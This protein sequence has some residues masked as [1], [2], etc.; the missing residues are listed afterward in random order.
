MKKRS[1]L[2]M[3]F[4]VAIGIIAG[5]CFG[6]NSS[7]SAPAGKEM[8][9]AT[10]DEQADKIVSNMT[11]SQKIGQLMMIGIEGKTLDKNA[12]YMLN[13]YKFGNLILFDRNMDNPDQVRKLTGDMKKAVKKNSGVEPL[14]ALDQEGGLVLRMRAHF[15]AIPSE[16]EIGRQD[17][18]QAKKWAM[19]T[20]DELKKLGF[21]VDFAPVV[22]LGSPRGR[23][24]SNDPDKVITYASQACQG[25]KESGVWSALK[26]FPGIGKAKIDP[27]IDGD[28]VSIS[29]AE[30]EQE[31]MK[32]F[33]ELIKTVDNNDTF[34]M[35]SNVT[36]PMLDSQYP[37]C[38]S[39]RI[40]TDI[41]RNEYG[42]KGL[43]L[44]DDMEM[45]AMSKHYAFEDMGVRAILAGADMVIV[46]HEYG[47]EQEVYNGLLKAYRDGRLSHEMVDE[48]VTRIVKTKLVHDLNE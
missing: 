34:V 9:A 5:G 29:R 8:K 43:I 2:I 1:G 33:R 11:E 21:N 20:G 31:D 3:A 19:T 46:C 15:P 24:F 41:L 39:E 44:T 18:S 47:H 36:Y 40:M 28:S 14:I 10:I 30:L 13:E 45:G 42:Y 25:Y 32:P 16:S 17:P 4:C 38:L 6:G 37:A 35:V 23:S 26:H 12:A 7:S 22:D 48:K 27:H